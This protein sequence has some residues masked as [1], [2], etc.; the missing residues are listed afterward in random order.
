MPSGK[1]RSSTRRDRLPTNW[2]N[3]I[4][5]LVFRQWGTT[6]HVCGLDGADD[7][8][9][10][11]AGDDHSLDNLRPIHRQPCHAQKSAAEGVEAARARREQLRHPATREEHPGL[12]RK[13]KDPQ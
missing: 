2:K 11:K 3:Q 4:R 6:C 13:S 10:V 8:D 1:W 9:H 7:V 5:P 12:L